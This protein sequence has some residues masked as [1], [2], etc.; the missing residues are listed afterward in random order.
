MEASNELSLIGKI[1]D[2]ATDPSKWNAA[3]T[4]LA[5]FF[6]S[7][8][9]QIGIVDHQDESISF[10]HT[11]GIEDFSLFPRYL[12]LLHD[13]PIYRI[14]NGTDETLMSRAPCGRVRMAQIR[15]GSAF[16]CREAVDAV[17][18]RAS[19]MYREVRARI[20]MEFSLL[21][22]FRIAPATWATVVL[23]RRPQRSAYDLKDC[24]MLDVLG[25]HVDRALRIF[26]RF[27]RMD[28]ERRT[29]LELLDAVGL[30]IIV[31][32]ESRA[33]LYQNRTAQDVLTQGDGLTIR[34]NR[35]YSA[36]SAV[37]RK[38]NG[39]IQR[40][41]SS[42]PDDLPA[43]G[44]AIRVDRSTKDIPYGLLISPLSGSLLIVSRD[45]QPLPAAAVLITDPSRT[46]ALDPERL[47]TL[48]ALTR[49]Q[50]RVAAELAKGSSVH[51]I[52]I[53]LGIQPNT[54]RTH[55][56]AIFR[57]TGCES[58]SELVRLLLQSA[59]W[60]DLGNVPSFL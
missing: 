43:P 34:S 19:R 33:L 1:Y 11:H 49:A 12:E 59:P 38:I 35:L 56:K 6:E 30:G 18:L 57:V 31:V 14:L 58:Q 15:E 4:E 39:A 44:E 40:A 41:L 32:D 16:H 8:F 20:G 54:V 52:A 26:L 42:T 22:Q 55:L 23:A 29:A 48:F 50:A 51:T 24:R 53:E 21:K 60:F 2:T 9:A 28:V 5:R 3:L 46:V 36:E 25:D 10:L 37:N 17:E 13:D 27:S 7:D 47:R 45:G